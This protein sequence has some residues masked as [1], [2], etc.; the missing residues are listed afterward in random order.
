MKKQQ[1]KTHTTEQIRAAV[2]LHCTANICSITV[3]ICV[4]YTHIFLSIVSV[5]ITLGGIKCEF[6][7]AAF[8]FTISVCV[9]AFILYI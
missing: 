5:F 7:F 6:I 1:K 8:R 9:R 4:I 3:F 2:H